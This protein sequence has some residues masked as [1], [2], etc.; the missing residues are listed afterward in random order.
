FSMRIV[1]LLPAAT[2]IIAALGLIDQLAGVSHEC[3]YPPEVNEK[4]RVTRCPIYGAGLSSAEVDRWVTE[5][6]A[7][8]GDL[9]ELDVELL[10][11]L[12]PD[13][14]VTQQL[15]EVC[16]ISGATVARALASLRR[17]P[18][19][20]ELAPNCLADIFEDIRRVAGAAR[21]PERAAALIKALTQRVEFVR[22]RAAQTT[23]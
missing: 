9:Y 2:E 12:E 8:G 1:S 11:E 23:H 3:D 5:T 22:A 14:I 6:L 13:L 18:R 16:S 17:A 7:S 19:L 10:K 4:P 20:I 21:V 15:C